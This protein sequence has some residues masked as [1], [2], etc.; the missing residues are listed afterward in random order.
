MRKFIDVVAESFETHGDLRIPTYPAR[1]W[2]HMLHENLNEYDTIPPFEYDPMNL[3]DGDYVGNISTGMGQLKVYRMQFGAE[4]IFGAGKEGEDTIADITIEY[5]GDGLGMMRSVWTAVEARGMGV[6]SELALF[7]HAVVG[8]T[9]L[10]DT[11]L[12]PQGAAL[13]QSLI[14]SGNFEVSIFDMKFRKY[15]KPSEIGS[16]TEDGVVILDPKDDD[17]VDYMWAPNHQDGQ[18]FFWA[19]KAKGKITSVVEGETY[20]YSV[21][22]MHHR[23]GATRPPRYFYGEND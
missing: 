1:A 10:N 4:V 13:R 3:S 18:R 2:S 12:T 23:P 15:H 7:V 19:L 5:L 11:T 16:E 8:M 9:I 17:D 6:A 21:S 22:P 20:E 14:R